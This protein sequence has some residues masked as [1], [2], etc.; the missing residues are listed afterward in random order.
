M[1]KYAILNNPINKIEK[2]MV[3]TFEDD[4]VYVFFYMI[5]RL[6]IPAEKDFETALFFVALITIS[7][8]PIA[9]LYFLDSLDL[10]KNNMIT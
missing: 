5:Q 7:G 9:N 3:F 4:E 2:V 10:K 6:I 8:A 1:C